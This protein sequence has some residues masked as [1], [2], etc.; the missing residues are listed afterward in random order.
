[1]CSLVGFLL[2]RRKGLTS[3]MHISRLLR[4]LVT[5]TVLL[6]LVFAL[7]PQ[8]IRADASLVVNTTA[9][10]DGTGV[11]CSLR[12]AIKAAKTDVDYGGCVGSG[13]YG[14]DT[15][16]FD[17]GVFATAQT[18]TLTGNLPIPLNSSVMTITGPGASLLTV[19]G[20]N[21]YRPFTIAPN[22]FVKISGVT[23]S[24]GNGGGIAVWS[25]SVLILSDS[26]ISNNVTASDGGGIQVSS[27]SNLIVSNTK[28]INNAAGGRG[29]AIDSSTSSVDV[30]DSTFSGNSAT[31][32]GGAI[33][34]ENFS[35]LTVSGSTFSGNSSADG[36]SI[37][38][39]GIIVNS[40]FSGNT[41]SDQGGAVYN[42][43]TGILKFIN[44]T[45]SGNTA[46]SG[47]GVY[48]AN[49]PLTLINSIVAN[50]SGGDCASSNSTLTISYSLIEDGSC[51]IT[52]GV[53]G[54]L[55]GD[56]LL[57][58][59]GLQNHGGLT[60]TIALWFISPAKDTGDNAGATN[61]FGTALTTDQRGTGYDRIVYSTVDMG[62]YEYQMDS[63]YDGLDDTWEYAHFGNLNQT[64][65]DDPD[66]DGCNNGCEEMQGLDPNNPDTDGDMLKDGEE[67][68]G[69]VTSTGTYY[70]NPLMVDSDYDGISDYNE[71]H[72]TPPTNPSPPDSDSDG[73]LDVWERNFFHNLDQFGVDDPDADL[74]DNVCEMFNGT[75]PLSADSDG[76]ALLDSDEM[77]GVYGY[78][79]NPLKKDTE[80]DGLWD[81]DEVLLYG[82]NPLVADTD[83]DG[84]KDGEE[85]NQYLTSPIQTDSDADGLSDY[86]EVKTYFTNP[87]VADS[88]ADG[89]NDYAEVHTYGT[90]PTQADTD[91]DGLTDGVEVQTY[92]TD[93]L[94]V[95]TDDD[96]LTDG[97]EVNT[98]LTSPILADSDNDTTP[99]NLGHS[100]SDSD[101]LFTYFT[102]PLDADTD[103]DGFSDYDELFVYDTDP[104]QMN[105]AVPIPLSP[106]NGNIT[107]NTR[108]LFTWSAVSDI[109]DYE[110]KLDVVN[111]P[112]AT[113]T[114]LNLGT[115][116]TPPGT[117]YAGTYYWQVRALGANGATS[118]WSD[119]Q[120]LTIDST[121]DAAPT[122]NVVSSAHPIFTWSPVTLATGY[123]VEIA[124]DSN[125]TILVRTSGLLPSNATSYASPD[126]LS[127]GTWYWRI[128]ARNADN[129]TWGTWSTTEMVQVR[130]IVP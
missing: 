60:Q 39:N 85:V 116:F 53:N 72:G 109:S 101:E 58:S 16:T 91:E 95:D 68:Y 124:A 27:I 77:H 43:T 89:L 12:E 2:P 57:D 120:T 90:D 73:L 106:A 71:I 13:T 79:T 30:T 18:I 48:T 26:I 1:M 129:I 63:D 114:G 121:A 59:Q 123:E 41:A 69:M 76:D 81:G 24:Q 86:A 14:D 113:Y 111:P 19:S 28:F 78:V 22:A 83:S 17:S 42:D 97:E 65:T 88:D 46:L 21:L 44:S 67:I 61:G 103:Q 74:C 33:A 125:F 56:P 51:G 31:L 47:G 66:N 102:D 37:S 107:T 10:E 8:T 119:V 54:N 82:S 20:A 94:M 45:L 70:S 92:H 112:R 80:G 62:A 122:R 98:Y 128:H 117:L 108:P 93:P 55:T 64:G 99:N 40:T 7:T 126:E 35:D 75:N 96:G 100:L 115:S 11:N 49:S 5:L 32:A 127:N 15:I 29:G 84:L 36:G 9:D 105:P 4:L 50:S 25:S 118:P 23:I 3:K 38:G 87:I 110:I 130:V 104:T 34:N 52:N 6:V